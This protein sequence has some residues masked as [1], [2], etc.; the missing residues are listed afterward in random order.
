LLGQIDGAHP[1][2]ADGPNDLVTAELIITGRG[3]IY[4][5]RCGIVPADRAVE[6]ALDQ[7]LG[8]QS[9]NTTGTQIRFAVRA[10]WHVDQRRSSN[11]MLLPETL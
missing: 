3:C 2:F 9:R 11:F 7:A 1:A 8:T 10:V 5:L 6:S 4:G